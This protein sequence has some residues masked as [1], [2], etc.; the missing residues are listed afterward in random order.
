MRWTRTGQTNRNKWGSKWA[1]LYPYP[2]EG[3]G[4]QGSS[5]TACDTGAEF[6]WNR[7]DWQGSWW[8]VM[9]SSRVISWQYCREEGRGWVYMEQGQDHYVSPWDYP[10]HN[11]FTVL[12]SP[13][14]KLSLHSLN[15]IEFQLDRIKGMWNWFILLLVNTS[16]IKIHWLLLPSVLS[17]YCIL[18][19][20]VPDKTNQSDLYRK[21]I[22]MVSIDQ[23]VFYFTLHQH[24]II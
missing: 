21:V 7:L 17:C 13:P 11:V 15:S 19:I 20:H 10:H 12:K 16:I 3:K 23:L 4:R 24:P 8:A 2:G 14:L 5:G 9:A 6:S 22:W 18:Q 1:T